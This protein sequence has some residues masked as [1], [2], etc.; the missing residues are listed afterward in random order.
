MVQQAEREAMLES[1]ERHWWYRGRRLVVGAE[2]ERLRPPAAARILDAGCGSGRM[3]DELRRF[4]AATGVDVDPGSVER[5]RARGHDA[6][7][8]SILELPFR[9]GVFRLTTCLDV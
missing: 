8:A 4:G 2:L 3:L 7:V 5:A 1:D 6:L 9:D